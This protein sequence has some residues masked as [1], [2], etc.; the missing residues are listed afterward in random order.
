MQKCF[1]ALIILTLYTASA[2]L[3]QSDSETSVE[4]S[5]LWETS[6]LNSPEQKLTALLQIENLLERGSQ[7][8]SMHTTL[9]Y[10]SLGE[11]EHYMRYMAVKLLGSLGTTEAKNTLI[12]VCYSEKD[13][14]I[15]TE[16]VKSLGIICLNDNNDTI[17][18]VIRVTYAHLEDYLADPLVFAALDTLDKVTEKYG[19]TARVIELISRI[20]NYQIGVFGSRVRTK[21]NQVFKKMRSYSRQ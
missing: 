16:A 19:I 12:K 7:N 4:E 1:T 15:L 5:Y 13:T 3:G 6:K 2:L 17:D 9:E 18:A 10:L 14:M 11:N 20:G 21:A 8:E